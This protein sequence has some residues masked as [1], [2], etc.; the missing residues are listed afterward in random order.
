MRALAA[1]VI[2]AS[3]AALPAARAEPRGP[4]DTVRTAL[5]NLFHGRY[6]ATWRLLPRAQQRLISPA[7]FATCSRIVFGPRDHDYVIRS[8]G[9]SRPVHLW[10][11]GAGSVRGLRVWLRIENRR[12]GHISV[13]FQDAAQVNGSWRWVW[14]DAGAFH[15]SGRCPV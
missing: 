7:R 13:W 6:A 10:L 8:I 14:R 11:H 12:T 1:L 3:L 5:T 2:A 4:V 15:E 9:G